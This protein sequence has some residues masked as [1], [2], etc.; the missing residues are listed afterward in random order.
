M[1]IEIVIPILNEE[2]TLKAQIEK[3]FTY[4]ELNQY[5]G[6]SVTVTIANNGS[7]DKSCKIAEQLCKQFCNLKYLEVGSIGVGKALKM[8]WSTSKADIVGFMDLDFATDL[9]H[10]EQSWNLI[11][12]NNFDLVYGSRNTKSSLVENRKISRN[13][14][15]KVFNLIIKL[16][17]KTNFSDGMC[18][19]KFMRK[20]C[21]GTILSEGIGFDGWFI[22]TEI[23]IMAEILNLR[24]YELP[25]KWTD[26]P[27][28]QVK[29]VTLTAIYLRDIVKLKIYLKTN[30]AKLNSFLLL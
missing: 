14:I 2:L 30:F 27:N 15:S 16:I 10:L 5:Y 23:L 12:K 8:A 26:S 6:H 20:D 9:K 29:V 21:V 19:F 4:L 3:L 22:S 11:E 1:N 13:I 24:I 18:G 17:F 28:S 25:I 7:R